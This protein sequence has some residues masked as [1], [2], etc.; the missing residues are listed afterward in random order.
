MAKL[1]ELGLGDDGKE[2]IVLSRWMSSSI[3]H[4]HQMTT[5]LEAMEE[6]RR[7]AEEALL[8][9]RLSPTLLFS[10]YKNPC[11]SLFMTDFIL[12]LYVHC[13]ST[14]QMVCKTCLKW[15]WRVMIVTWWSQVKSNFFFRQRSYLYIMPLSC[16][17]S[18][19]PTILV[20]CTTS[21]MWPWCV[22]M[23]ICQ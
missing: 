17:L 2:V 1:Y 20:I 13:M 9:G 12:D 10:L 8:V 19:Q 18:C 16:P 4:A 6:M 3:C 5:T 14:I 7:S 11:C 15:P 22:M 21:L 23:V